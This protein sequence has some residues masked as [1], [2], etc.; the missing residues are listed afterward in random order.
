MSKDKKKDK[1]KD[2]I[3]PICS[4][5]NQNLIQCKCLHKSLNK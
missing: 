3:I 1:K 2:A 4:D 5:C